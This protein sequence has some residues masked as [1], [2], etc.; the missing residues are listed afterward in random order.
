METKLEELKVR[1]TKDID[2]IPWQNGD[3]PGTQ[4]YNATRYFV[5]EFLKSVETLYKEENAQKRHDPRGKTS[6]G[7]QD[8]SSSGSQS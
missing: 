1:F 5:A 2:S 8:E 3:V 4:L 7:S 6:L